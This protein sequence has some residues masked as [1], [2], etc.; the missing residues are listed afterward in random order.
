[1]NIMPVVDQII[2]LFI[3]MGLGLALRKMN[4]FTDKVIKGVNLM[5]LKVT[6]PALM[7]MTTQREYTPDALDMFVKVLLGSMVIMALTTAAAYLACRRKDRRMAPVFALL[8]GLPNAGYIG[9]PIVGAVYGDAGTLYV[10]AYIIGFNLVLWTLGVAMFTGFSLRSLKNL[11]NP[12]LICAAVGITL[13]VLRIQ[14][15]APILS[16]VNQLGVVNTPL[17]MLL[18]GARLNTLRPRQL[19]DARL[20]QVV[21]VRL[22]AVPLATFAA[23]RLMGVEGM[24]LGMLVLPTALSSAAAGQMFAERYD[25]GVPFAVKCVSVTTLLSLL[26]LPLIMVLSGI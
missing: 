2:M 7:L 15:P 16:A 17:S 19:M 22:L 5:V 6:W 25:I 18:L 21:L 13:F 3:L 1:M 14:L 11:L 24:L 4:I 23:L 12:A 20:W 10:A 8:C 9:L 26:S